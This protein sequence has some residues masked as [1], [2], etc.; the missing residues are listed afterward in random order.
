MGGKSQVLHIFKDYFPEFDNIKGY[1]EPFIGGANVYFY[2][3]KHW[4]GKL[5]GKPIFISDINKELI[6]CYRSVRNSVDKMIP[7]LEEHQRLNSEKHYYDVRK[8][9]PPGKNMTNVEKAAAF[10]YL[11]RSA[12]GGLWRVN[13]QGKM[14]APFNKNPNI[15]I[16]DRELKAELFNYAGM[17]KH[18]HINKMSFENIVNING[19]NLKGYFI[20]MDPPY[21]AKA[22]I[23]AFTGYSKDG[24]SA[25]NR[26][27][28]PKVFKEL[29]KRGAK[30]MMSNADVPAMRS[31]FSDFNIHVI[32]TNRQTGIQL[33]SIT[34]EKMAN[35]DK[36]NE[37]VITN[38]EFI[39]GK[40]QK[41]IDDYAEG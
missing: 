2:I 29:D 28:L 41:T 24:Y 18:A 37:V 35:T 7:L 9:Y 10:I 14:N 15:K 25:S 17:L 36:L 12:F 22:D 27:L 39:S 11:S 19:G 26:D 38:Y 16:I 20:Y 1:I 3:M 30:V 4:G 8:E 32:Q 31:T 6:N 40:K 33:S 23:N 5:Q 13:S 21:A 34:K